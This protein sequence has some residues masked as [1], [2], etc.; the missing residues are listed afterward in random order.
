LCGGLTQLVQS[1][2]EVLVEAGYQP[3][4]AYFECLHELKIIVDLLHQRGIGAMR[5]MIST[6]AE[7]GDVTC[8]P[9][10]IDNHV[11]D[12]MRTILN[13]IRSGAFAHEFLGE[14]K[15]GMA[16]IDRS[17]AATAQLEIERVGFE[18]R[19]HMPWLNREPRK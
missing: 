11:R 2:F 1:G 15:N 17:R 8:G 19:K 7:Y 6:T 13:R 9:E 16:S 12:N 14:V 10:I 5:E 4:L 18:L 3:E